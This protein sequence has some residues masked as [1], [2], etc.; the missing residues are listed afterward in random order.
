MRKLATVRKISAITPIEGADKIECASV[1]GWKVVVKK[2][3]F[4]V[5]DY[6]VYFEIDSWV[7]CEIAPFLC[8]K[9][10]KE[11]GGVVGARLRTVKMRGQ[12]SQ[13][14]LLPIH[15]YI[16]QIIVE[17]EDYDGFDLTDILGIQK[18]EKPVTN[19]PQARGNF[20]SFI[21]KTDAERIQNLRKVFNGIG[22]YQLYEVTTKLDGSSMTVY[23][24]SKD[25]HFGVCSRNME[26][27]LDCA[28]N[29]FVS[30][31]LKHDLESKMRTLGKS[32]AIQ[33]ELMGP[34]IQGNRENLPETKFYVFSI[35]DIDAGEYVDQF[36]RYRYVNYFG[37]NHVPVIEKS[38]SL[39]QLGI[40]NVDDALEFADGPSIHNKIREGVVFKHKGNIWKAISNKFL[41]KEK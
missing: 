11:Y 2:G 22:I 27:S 15:E 13:G 28:D 3:E 8:D 34:K 36:D 40:L 38:I 10:K 41:L 29:A 24:N 16:H 4:N 21:P 18:Y 14:L 31:A 32:F 12:I 5:G 7:P 37:L 17:E 25:D 26:L 19:A 33:G 35:Y 9:E 39:N 30:T 6:G 1:D 20:P 23:Y